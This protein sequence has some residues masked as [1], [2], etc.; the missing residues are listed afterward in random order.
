MSCGVGG[1]LALA[2]DVDPTGTA[3]TGVTLGVDEKWRCRAGNARPYGLWHPERVSEVHRTG[4]ALA[5][6]TRCSRLS[7]V[8]Q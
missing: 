8:G 3:A 1:L 7:T 6:A 5:N 4:E 2:L